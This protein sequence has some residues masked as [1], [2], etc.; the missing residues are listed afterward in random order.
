MRD[1]ERQTAIQSRMSREVLSEEA[2]LEESPKGDKGTA[3]LN[4]TGRS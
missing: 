3:M 4:P 2:E 1:R